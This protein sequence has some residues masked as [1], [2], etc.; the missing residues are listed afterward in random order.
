MLR[1]LFALVLVAGMVMAD[2]IFLSRDGQETQIRIAQDNLQSRDSASLVLDCHVRSVETE[3]VQTAQGTFTRVYIPGWQ[4]SNNPGAPELPVMTQIVQV[5]MGG[6]V[7]VRVLSA[8]KMDGEARQYGIA[9]SL[10]PNQPSVRKDQKEVSF[11]YNTEAYQQGFRASELV[12]VEEIGMM[13]DARLVSI[14]FMPVEYS[15]VD[16]KIAFYS[17]IQAEIVVENADMAATMELKANCASS[18]FQFPQILTPASLQYTARN[19]VGYLIVAHKM[20]EG[21]A[22]LQKFVAHKQ[23]IGYN[24]IVKY[25]ESATVDSVTAVIKEVFNAS[26][27]TF[28]LLVGDNEQIPGKSVGQYTDLYYASTM[29]GGTSDY[30]PDMLYGRFS[31]SNATD[32][33]AQINKTIAY[34]QKQFSD[35]EYL[36]KYAL[37]AGWDSS[38]AIKRGYPQ[39]RY[40][41]K[42]YFNEAKYVK[43]IESGAGRN[44]YLSSK[45]SDGTADIVSLISSGVGFFNYTAHG[46]QTNFS[47]PSF[48]FTNIDN[49]KNYNMYPLVIGNC[50]LT[51]SY[52]VATCFGEKWLRVADKGAIGFIGGSNYTY[53][54]EDLWF[55]VGYCQLTTEINAGQAP[56]KANTGAGM[57]EAGFGEFG[58][59]MP[60]HISCNA[61]VMVAGNLAVQA[62]TSSRKLYYWQVYHLFGDPSLPCYWAIK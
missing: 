60:F 17:D 15:P 6:Q 25:V 48:T 27:P 31:A 29:V 52:Q 20:F 19:A 37:V 2:E 61:A 54:D 38:W 42:Y 3:E 23:G 10:Y 56:V 53:W 40:A 32:L 5:P 39:I 49:L 9:N 44:V 35:A 46:S 8:L 1:I 51:G 45:S 30:M 24:V 36:K 34:E 50:C 55:G 16:G 22:L 57:Y 58:N 12:T 62:S 14:N 13:R 11:V 43:P 59:D 18:Y 21:N 47:D 4:S 28:L 7:S 26:K 33:E 41:V